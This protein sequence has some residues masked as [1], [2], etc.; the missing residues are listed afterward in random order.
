M[1]KL[2]KLLTK[3]TDNY[4]S[5]FDTDT[6]SFKLQFRTFISSQAATGMCWKVHRMPMFAVGSV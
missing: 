6:H 1:S 2:E 3:R 5:I 4:K